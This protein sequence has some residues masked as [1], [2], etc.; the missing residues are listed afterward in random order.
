MSYSIRASLNERQ[1]VISGTRSDLA[2]LASV[3]SDLASLSDAAL[4]TPAN[5]FHFMPDFCNVTADSFSFV[6][7]A[8]PDDSDVT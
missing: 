2:F 1:F 8:R 5:H 3:C 6:L 7:M 4:E